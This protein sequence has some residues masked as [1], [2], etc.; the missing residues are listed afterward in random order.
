MGGQR[1]VSPVSFYTWAWQPQLVI[2]FGGIRFFVW[3]ANHFSFYGPKGYQKYSTHTRVPFLIPPLPSPLPLPLRENAIS[4]N[5][6]LPRQKVESR[7][8]QTWHMKICCSFLALVEFPFCIFSIF[9]FLYFSNAFLFRV[10]WKT[11]SLDK[12]V[13]YFL[14]FFFVLFWRMHR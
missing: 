2:H 12:R 1:P 8:R 3:A 4:K 11:H 6:A 14:F 5:F 13:E 10:F 9:R 7:K